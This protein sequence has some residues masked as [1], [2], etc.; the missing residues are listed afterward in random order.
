MR[1]G[2][3]LRVLLFLKGAVVIAT[4][5]S[6]TMMGVDGHRVAVEVHV[7]NGLPAFT[8]VGLPDAACREARDRVRA[9]VLSSGLEW[10]ARK[11]T[12]NLAPSSLRKQGSVADLAI[13]IGCLVAS[14]VLDGEVIANTAFIGELGLDGS[15]R[16]VPGVVPLVDALDVD[17]VIVPASLVGQASVVGKAKVY[18]A[19]NLGQLV[20]CLRGESPWEAPDPPTRPWVQEDPQLSDVRG[21]PI[22][23]WALEVAA[24]G[25]HNLMFN[26]SPGSGKTMLAR[27]LPGL[28]PDLATPEALEVT[29]IHSAAGQLGEWGGLVVRPPFRAPHH[30]SSTVSMTGGGSGVMRPGEVSLAHRGVL[31]LDEMAEFAPRSIDAL[32]QPLEEGV[33]HIARAHSS[34][35]FPASFLCVGATNPC[36]CGEVGIECRCSDVVRNR[37]TSRISGPLLDRFDLRVRVERPRVEEFFA[38]QPG[39]STEVVKERV[40]AARLRALLRQGE[41]NARLTAAGLMQFAPLDAGSLAMLRNEMR[42]GRLTARG[43]NRVHRVARTLADLEGSDA[44]NEGHVASALHLRVDQMAAGRSA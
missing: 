44:V 4:V 26:G 8:L 11:I 3:A 36:P 25:G 39:E 2:V 28:L 43:L 32:R 18:G 29:K 6:A 19:E 16:A 20:A 35:S 22:A 34:V 9:A 41:L 30:S 10:K 17:R 38:E 14:G 31:F 1:A 5:M 21:Q 7:S 27:R 13:A 40:A 24:A 12:V 42:S 23:C 37:Y 33:I 15:L